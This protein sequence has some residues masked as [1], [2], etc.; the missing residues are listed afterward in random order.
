MYPQ[1]KFDFQPVEPEEEEWDES[2]MNSTY[3]AFADTAEANPPLEE[4]SVAPIERDL[5]IPSEITLPPDACED[6]GNCHEGIMD[7]PTEHATSL[8][9][10]STPDEQL[11]GPRRSTRKKWRPEY[12]KDYK[13]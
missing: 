5:D 10:I 3:P 7:S 1:N 4:I 11:Q 2:D 6:T 9:F 13:E 12:L 8:P